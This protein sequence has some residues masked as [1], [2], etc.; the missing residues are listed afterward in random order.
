MRNAACR[1]TT[2]ASKG[3]RKSPAMAIAAR[4]DLITFIR[5]FGPVEASASEQVVWRFASPAFQLIY[6]NRPAAR[7]PILFQ[8]ADQPVRV[9]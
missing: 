1:R 6:V 5:R 7:R 2:I 4:D 8:L 3:W 9:T